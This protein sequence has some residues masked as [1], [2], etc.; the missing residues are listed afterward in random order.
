MACTASSTQ[1]YT[2]IEV[3]NAAGPITVSHARPLVARTASVLICRQDCHPGRPALLTNAMDT[4]V[5]AFVIEESETRCV[6]LVPTAPAVMAGSV[7]YVS[8]AGD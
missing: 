8:K 5:L 3:T 7:Q 4:L 2:T 6:V 1:R